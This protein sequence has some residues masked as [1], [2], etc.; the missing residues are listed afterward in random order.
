MAS[1]VVE[2][3]VEMGVEMVAVADMEVVVVAVDLFL[4]NN[5]LQPTSK[6]ALISPS[7]AA[8]RCQDRNAPQHPNSSV[9]LFLDNSV[10][11][12]QDK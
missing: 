9:A 3:A 4:S 6:F 5:A 12:F 10:D 7:K 2:I 8:G 1:L 11:P